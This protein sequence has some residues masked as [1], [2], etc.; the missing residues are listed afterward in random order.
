MWTCA[1]QSKVQTISGQISD[2]N[3]KVP[4]L[5]QVHLFTLGGNP[6]KPLQTVKVKADGSFEIAL[7]QQEFL[8]IMVTAANH[9][10]L[11]FPIIHRSKKKIGMKIVLKTNEY[12]S[13]FSQLK[14][15]GDW[16]KFSWGSASD[17]QRQKDGRYFYDDS[18]TADTVAYQLLNLVKDNRS[19]NGTMWDR[20]IYDGG[21][22]YI[23]VVQTKQGKAHIVFDPQKLGKTPQINKAEV[24]ITKGDI[25]MQPFI[26]LA[27]RTEEVA[28]KRTAAA[29]TYYK[30]NK[31]LKGFSFENETFRKYLQDKRTQ[32]NDTL[33]AQYAALQTAKFWQMNGRI[34]DAAL[35]SLLS[36][37]PLK[38][39]M[40][41][42]APML[43]TKVVEAALGPAKADSVFRADLLK[44]KNEQVKAAALIPLGL[45]AKAEN[46]LEKMADIYKQ[47]KQIKS[48]IPGYD[49]YVD[50]LNPNKN[51]VK[52]KTI[53]DFSFTLFD[54]K[55]T[56]S[57]KSLSGKYYIMDFWATWRSPCVGE[58]PYMHK[59]YSKFKHK[60]FTILSLSFDRAPEAVR[61]FT[62]GQWKMPWLNVF[63]TPPERKAADK[64]FEI[65][66]IPK[67]ILVG[68]DG[69]I[70]ATEM[71][72]RGEQLMQTLKKYVK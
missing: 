30:Q 49:Y 11:Q 17:M 32:Q 37:I 33:L 61:H 60:N 65:N 40:W 67:P 5:A 8:E 50:Q 16:N 27:L 23:S 69:K 26:D 18:T 41:Q 34:D 35:R 2:V 10:K 42:A 6:F 39:A 13:D 66:G 31:N 4:A 68:P 24:M 45:K 7:P 54:S 64:K 71:E 12:N 19:V 46:Q 62:A 58:M 36:I 25:T 3:G 47:L 1:K 56:V 44:I 51:I 52:G 29:Q 22:D 72:L 63:L 28:A 15:V 70:L 55:K 21:G 59:A 38:S 43:A 20:L 48:T 57:K 53:P 14:I 9:P